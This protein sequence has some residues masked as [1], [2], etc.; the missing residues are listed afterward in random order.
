[1]SVTIYTYKQQGN[2]RDSWHV[3]VHDVDNENQANSG[4]RTSRK[5]IFNNP[6][7]KSYFVPT[8][9][10]E[11]N[12]LASGNYIGTREFV[13]SSATNDDVSQGDIVYFG[14]GTPTQGKVVYLKNNGQWQ[15]ADS[16]G[17]TA[18][19]GMLGIAL[20]SSPTSDGILIRGMYTLDHDIGDTPGL[21]LYLN[22]GGN[23]GRATST[24]PSTSGHVVRVLGYTLGSN[25]EIWFDPNKTWIKLS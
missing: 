14:S 23:A 22:S 3:D 24:A 7:K 1:M 15:T 20:G 21:P 4:N 18:S 10:F 11:G 9:T 6:T 25:D 17:E 12:I 13:T 5:L 19:K 2:G 8:E 16:S